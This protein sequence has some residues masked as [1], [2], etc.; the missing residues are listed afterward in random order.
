MLFVA[1]VVSF[2]EDISP[3]RMR[4][5]FEAVKTPF[6]YGVILRGDEGK[7]V[8]CPSVFRRGDSWYMV[9]IC[10]N[11]IG[12]E[13]H[14]ARS[15]DLCHW[16]KLGTILPFSKTGWDAWQGAGTVALQDPAWGG[17]YE[18]KPVADKYWMSYLGGARQGYE[19]D[20]LAIG[21]AW[22]TAPDLPETW[23]R[24]AEN[25]VLSPDQ[26]DARPFEAATLYRS[27]I[28]RDETEQTGYPFVM[29]YN[30]KQQGP[31][32]ER[33][34][35]AGSRDLIHWRRLGSG[36][37]IDNGRGISGDPQ[38]ARMGDMWVMFYYGAFWKPGAFDTFAASNDLVHWTRWDGPPLVEPSE[39]W[40]KRYA[41]KPWVIAHE[42]VVYHFYCAVGDQ[43][44][45]I[46]LATSKDL[47]PAKAV[48]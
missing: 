16:E 47:G 38:I 15:R 31:A 3:D 48:R 37:V 29:Y 26:P 35:M 34:G 27:F 13:T 5:I 22:T 7:A 1:S 8:D 18:L 20:P 4:Q 10:M 19:T 2:A 21:M 44:R 40:D 33:I 30:G 39:P 32:T 24:I 46:A 12:Y 6:K 17:R 23:H 9:Y 45:V 14:L 36:P 41:H 43:G 25:P 42:G 11:Q 28:L